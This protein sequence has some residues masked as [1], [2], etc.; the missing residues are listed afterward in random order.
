MTVL[1]K[2]KG[3]LIPACNI[4]ILETI[5]VSICS[6]ASIVQKVKSAGEAVESLL[7]YK[8]QSLDDSS[9][10]G[11]TVTLLEAVLSF[12]CKQQQVRYFLSVGCDCIIDQLTNKEICVRPL[13]QAP[14]TKML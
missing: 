7:P 5:A 6:S 9:V 3:K 4:S 1:A 2:R 12:A 14:I 8:T 11:E 10:L 13:L